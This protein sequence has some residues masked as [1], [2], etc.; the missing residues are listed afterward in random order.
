MK[1]FDIIKNLFRKKPLQIEGNTRKNKENNFK[2]ELSEKYSNEKSEEQLS[3]EQF[4][5]KREQQLQF[6]YK[7][8]VRNGANINR[9]MKEDLEERLTQH[10]Y[11]NEIILSDLDLDI[12][13][14]LKYKI[15]NIKDDDEIIQYLNK[16]SQN[17]KKVIEKI[18][19]K[20][21]IEAGNW[22]EVK[23]KAGGYITNTVSTIKEVIENE[24]SKEK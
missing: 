6:A 17:V 23:E 7:N 21:I 9:G 15:G 3:L 20:A 24:K 22:G 19:E 16:N 4:E 12:M 11:D 18:E 8:I 1:I 5:Q 13:Y 10:G 14:D 2:E